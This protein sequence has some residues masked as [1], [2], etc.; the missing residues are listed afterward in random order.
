MKFLA[1]DIGGTAVKIGIL[2]E[3]GK[4]FVKSSYSVC[5]DHYQTPVLDTVLK[6]AEEFLSSNGLSHSGLSG[7][8]IA[9]TGQVDPIRGTVVGTAGHIP[10]WLHSPIKERFFERYHLPVSVINDANSVALAEHW[11]GAAKGYP[12]AVIITIGTGIGGGV[13]INSSLLEGSSGIAGELGHFSINHNGP[14]CTC[15]NHGCYEHYASTTALLSRI[16]EHYKDLPLSCPPDQINGFLVFD[17]L[18][19]G[20][21]LVQEIVAQWISNIADGL[22]SLTHIFNPDIILIGGGVSSQQELFIDKVAVQVKQRVMPQ[23][24]KNLTI[25]SAA[26][27]NDAGMIGAIIPLLRGQR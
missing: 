1:I 27:A 23:F 6:K 25:R 26:L 4:I 16:K 5:F 8:G 20:N 12:N 2:D 9:A 14:L 21:S 15:G 7:I 19:K 17:L 13:I 18:R 24:S 22:V 11:I 10:H 3:T